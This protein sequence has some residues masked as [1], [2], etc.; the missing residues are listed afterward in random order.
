[1]NCT[2]ARSWLFR[3][4]DG[5]LSDSEGAE[6]NAHLAEC[7]S[8]IREYGILT[9]PHRIARADSPVMPPPFFYQRLRTR[10]EAEAP[11]IAG[12]QAFQ[13]LA[14]SMVP[15]LAGITL[16]LLFVFAYFQVFN[17]Q[18]DP[19]KAYDNGEVISGDQSPIMLIADQGDITYESVLSAIAERD[20]N[21]RRNQGLK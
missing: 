13:E 21:H 2:I 14:R 7:A 4:I 9:L 8:C 19:Y 1:M 18:V 10:I 16:A 5:E 3:K 12:W 20:S 15:T 11:K 6:L 17:P